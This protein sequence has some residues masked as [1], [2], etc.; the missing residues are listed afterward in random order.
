MEK[1]PEGLKIYLAIILIFLAIFAFGAFVF[2]IR[3]FHETQKFDEDYPFEQPTQGF[4]NN[5]FNN[6]TSWGA[7]T[8]GLFLLFLAVGG[9][10]IAETFGCHLQTILTHNPWVKFLFLFMITYFATAFQSQST[11]PISANILKAIMVF[12]LFVLVSKTRKWAMFGAIFILIGIFM[13]HQQKNIEISQLEARKNQDDFE[14]KKNKLQKR[15]KIYNTIQIVLFVVLF[16]VVVMGVLMY[17]K[18]QVLERGAVEGK[19]SFPWLY[20]LDSE[21]N[22]KEK[23]PI[24]REWLWAP[25]RDEQDKQIKFTVEP[26]GIQKRLKKN[27]IDRSLPPWTLVKDSTSDTTFEW[28]KFWGL[29]GEPQECAGT[30]KYAI[31]CKNNYCQ[32][33]RGP[34]FPSTTECHKRSL[35]NRPCGDDATCVPKKVGKDKLDKKF[36]FFSKCSDTPL[37]PSKNELQ[38]HFNV[39]RHIQIVA[40]DLKNESKSNEDKKELDGICEET[41]VLQ[42][43]VKVL[44]DSDISKGIPVSIQRQMADGLQRD[45]KEMIDRLGNLELLFRGLSKH[46]KKP[47]E[48]SDSYKFV[49]AYIKQ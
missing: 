2:G 27:I 18:K 25:K 14:I 47:K 5:S 17:V 4:F 13:L 3:R 33:T 36:A 28:L 29:T 21:E 23:A 46:P 49:D 44:Q 8:S 32:H 6:V 9:N 22:E 37:K 31:K 12:I 48:L 11:E 19:I 16:C 38:D 30:S 24:D 42:G 43:E 39:F 45:K 1:F 40:K 10:F 7:I 34:Q 20:G 41:R 26:G 15:F 35:V